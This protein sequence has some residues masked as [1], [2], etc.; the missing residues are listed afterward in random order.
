MSVIRSPHQPVLCSTP[1]CSTWSCRCR[2]HDGAASSSGR[3]KAWGCATSLRAKPTYPRS[4]RTSAHVSSSLGIFWD[5]DNVRWRGKE[6]A[7]VARAAFRIERMAEQ[8]RPEGGAEFEIVFR[9]Y[10]P[11]ASPWFASRRPRVSPGRP[12]AFPQ[13]APCERAGVWCEPPTAFFESCD[14]RTVDRGQA[15]R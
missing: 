15:T 10:G 11:C 2:L 3:N 13:P 6:A 9:A 14:E 1:P 12:P 5:V 4:I 7:S 8:L